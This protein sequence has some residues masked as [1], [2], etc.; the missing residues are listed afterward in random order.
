M[1]ND[2]QLSWFNSFNSVNFNLMKFRN[3]KESIRCYEL[4]FEEVKTGYN[5][6]SL[7]RSLGYTTSGK[8]YFY[9]ALLRIFYGSSHN[10]NFMEMFSFAIFS[11]LN[12][13]DAALNDAQLN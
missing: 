7:L 11:C 4:L 13:E 3:I 1:L 2:A 9:N 12:Y 10:K 6:V 8:L 5:R